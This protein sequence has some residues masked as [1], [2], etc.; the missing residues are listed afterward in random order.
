MEDDAITEAIRHIE[1]RI[2]T[3]SDAYQTQW[4]ALTTLDSR[5]SV[6]ES[7]I[8]DVE[9]DIGYMESRLMQR[10]DEAEARATVRADKLEEAQKNV[11]RALWGLSGTLVA[12][13]VTIALAVQ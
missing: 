7:K 5:E 13:A 4:A 2:V 8:E 9:K 12:V 10:T 11:G 1:S 6:L 3:I